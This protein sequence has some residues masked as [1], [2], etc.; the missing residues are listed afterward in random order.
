MSSPCV[1]AKSTTKPA[2][3]TKAKKSAK[4]AAKK[5]RP[6]RAPRDFA[7]RACQPQETDKMVCMVC[8]IYFE[9]RGETHTG[10]VA[11]GRTTLTR[12]TRP[13]YPGSICEVIWQDGQFSWTE[14]KI[15]HL[16][17]R[18]S[19]DYATLVDSVKAAKDVYRLGPNGLTNFCNPKKSKCTWRN[20]PGCLASQKKIGRH[21]FCRND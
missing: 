10:K 15:K 17:S 5:K 19:R 1:H 20:S 12:I 13:E 8:N 3:K 18:Q 9:A 14:G 16:P 7:G 6:P 11:V 2:A 4:T 21:L